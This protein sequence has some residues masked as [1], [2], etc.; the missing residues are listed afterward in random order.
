MCPELLENP[1]GTGDMEVVYYHLHSYLEGA[2]AGTPLLATD[3]VDS[4]ISAVAETGADVDE[5]LLNR[6]RLMELRRLFTKDLVDSILE[7]DFEYGIE[8]QAD[9]LVREKMRQ[10]RLATKAWL[11]RVFLDHFSNVSVLLGVL[12]IAA[13]LD[14][15]EVYPEGQTMALAA[16]SHWS[17]LVQECGVRAF[18]SW[19]TSDSLDILEN[20]NTS[21]RWL[22]A[23]VD[24]VVTDLRGQLNAYTR[25][26]DR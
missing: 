6:V 26:E 17:V 1:S 4:A 21:E 19:E 25:Q 24:E 16:L 13:R 15:W 12:R 8:T 3:D 9:R 22:Q 7:E 11:N 14:Y 10:N 2:Q 20:V 23:Y 5:N 18:E